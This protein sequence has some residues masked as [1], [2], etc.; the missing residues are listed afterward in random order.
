MGYG[1]N[2]RNRFSSLQVDG[3]NVNYFLK[4]E[5]FNLSVDNTGDGGKST[6]VSFSKGY[7]PSEVPLVAFRPVSNNEGAGLWR[8]A[9]SGGL[10]TG[11]YFTCV[12]GY[13]QHVDWRVYALDYYESAG[14]DDFGIEIRNQYGKEVFAS[15]EQAMRFNLGRS[16]ELDWSDWTTTFVFDHDEE[17]PFFVLQPQGWAIHTIIPASPFPATYGR[18][19]VQRITATQTKVTWI[20]FYYYSGMGGV[21]HAGSSP[22]MFFG[23]IPK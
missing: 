10:I 15:R 14:N 7:L 1:L 11:C 3:E 4:E 6:L 19:G 20:P 13:T 16:V 21:V 5:G 2:I 22:P 23:I 9:Y 17:S 12:R 8:F 18:T